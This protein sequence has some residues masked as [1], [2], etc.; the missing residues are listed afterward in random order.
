MT[1]PTKARVTRAQTEQLLAW[2]K[3][4]QPRVYAGLL[5]RFTPAS[6]VSGLFDSITG[7]ASKFVD[8]VTNFFNSNG[9]QAVLTA[10]TPFLQTSLEKKQLQMNL[11]RMQNGLPMQQ[12]PVGGQAPDPYGNNQAFFPTSSQSGVSVPWLWLGIG[13]LGLG[14][15]LSR[16]RAR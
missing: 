1:S 9:G 10:A 13:G 16:R 11:T 2:M 4:T 8:S 5:R 12:Y 6:S 7:I 3:A 14:L 15:L